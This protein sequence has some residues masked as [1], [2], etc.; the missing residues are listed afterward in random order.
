MVD[1]VEAAAQRYRAQ[2]IAVM[3]DGLVRAH[4]D[5]KTRDVEAAEALYRI[6]GELDTAAMI[7][8]ITK[9]IHKAISEL[10]ASASD[11]IFEKLSEVTFTLSATMAGA[12]RAVF[13]RGATPTVVRTLRTEL[14]I[15][16]LA[17]VKARASERA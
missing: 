15:M 6:A 11:A 8:T 5:A 1:A 17:Y 10:L 2:P 4:V 12:C 7:A 9:R 13:E 16:C 14:P 3:A